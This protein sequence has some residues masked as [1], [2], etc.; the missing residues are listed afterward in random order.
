LFAS[1]ASLEEEAHI[2]LFGH[3]IPSIRNGSNGNCSTAL[4]ISGRPK[5]LAKSNEWLI[6]T[7]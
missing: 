4:A 6:I 3:A 5:E 7:L 2:K 1:L